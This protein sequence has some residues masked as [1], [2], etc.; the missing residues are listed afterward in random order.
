MI[1]VKMGVLVLHFVSLLIEGKADDGQLARKS[2]IINDSGSK[3][4]KGG[5]NYLRVTEGGPEYFPKMAMGGDQNFF[6]HVERGTRIFMRMPRG[7]DQIFFSH[8]KGDQ[9]KLATRD[10]K[11]TSPPSGKK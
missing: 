3:G 7:G 4:I 1:F 11:Q 2:G 9:K 5:Q 8:A 10:H 6:V